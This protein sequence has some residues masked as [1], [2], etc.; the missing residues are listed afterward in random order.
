MVFGEGIETSYL[1]SLKEGGGG[2]KAMLNVS[3]GWSR[4]TVYAGDLRDPGSWGIIYGGEDFRA[5]TIDHVE[6]DYLVASYDGEGLGRIVAVSEEGG[7]RELLGEQE[8]SLLDATVAGEKI[9]VNYL[10]DASSTIRTFGLDGSELDAFT[11]EAAGSVD[12]L[13]TAWGGCVFRYQSFVVPHRIY[14]L[15]EGRLSILASE[16]VPGEFEVGESWVKSKDG[17]RIHSFS[18]KRRGAQPDKAY[19][20]GYGGFSIPLTPRFFP[21]VIPFIEDGGA[22]VH[23]NLRGGVEY[24]E[25]WHRAG[26]RERKQNVFDDYASVLRD[27]KENGKRVVAFGRSN[28]GL[29]V[30]TTMTQRPELLDGAVIGYPVLDMRRFHKLYVGKSWVPEYGDPDDPGDAKFLAEYSPYHHIRDDVSYPPIFMY[31]G[32]HDDRVHPGHAFKFGAR[33]DD[34]G[35]EYLLRVEEMSGHAGATPKTKIEEESDIMAFVYKAL[36]MA[37]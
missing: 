25:A 28:G 2:A 30:G 8:Y 24:G 3:Y 21:F 18:V 12:F 7:E 35:H 29:L 14:T 10:V 32:I 1:I 15:R 4:S 33:L 22:Y 23:T 20:F 6:G 36:G 17:T 37:I 26:M 16:D 11:F 19:V 31:T 34:A 13:R 9:V 5:T 27:L